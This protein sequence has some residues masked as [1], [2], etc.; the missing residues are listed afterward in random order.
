MKAHTCY[1]TGLSGLYKGLTTTILKQSSNQAVRL[2]VIEACKEFYTNHP[3]TGE[4]TPTLVVG[5]F[6]VFAG[7]ISAYANSPVD[8]VK[9][10]MQSLDSH[11]YSS[12]WDCA[13]QMWHNEGFRAFYKG[14]VARLAR[15]TTESAFTFMA[16]DAIVQLL[17][18]M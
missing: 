9:T 13:R 3:S 16:Y 12:S 2:S 8:V 7:I 5:V 17:T 14:S 10:R 6:G 15:V 4:K 11:R 18:K 1:L